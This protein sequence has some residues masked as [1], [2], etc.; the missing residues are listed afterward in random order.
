MEHIMLCATDAGGARNIAP[1]LGVIK[2]RG[3]KPVLI[4]SKEMKHLFDLENV[5]LIE[6]TSNDSSAKDYIEKFPPKAIFCGTTRYPSI[7]RYLVR[8]GKNQGIKTTVVLDEWF[9]HRLRFENEEGELE[10]LPDIIACM[11]EKAKKGAICEGIPEKLCRVTGSPSLALLTD[12]AENFISDPYPLPDFLKSRKN[13][14]IITFLSQPFSS[15]YGSKKGDH[16]PL[17]KYL[18]YTENTVKNDIIK[19]VK[20]INKKC[21]VVEKLHPSSKLSDIEESLTENIKWIRIKKT[22]L[23]SLFWY[24]QAVIGMRSMAL[25]ESKIFNRPTISYQ[26]GLLVKDVCTAVS[27]GFVNKLSR[28]D[29]LE[30][31]LLNELNKDNEQDKKS[32]NRYSFA[33]K[34]AAENV[35]SITVN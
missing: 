27:F 25:L 5:E 15:D 31:W 34:D 9:N 35:V 14:P 11:D 17:G 21:T 16:G 26:P 3:F 2:K 10:F 32:I 13:F 20:K 1:L 8:E 28:P 23:W 12:R 4:T 6:T 19:V 30:K 7:D 29:E 33:R 24:S 22:D 18:G